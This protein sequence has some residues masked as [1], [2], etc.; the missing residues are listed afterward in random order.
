MSKI[1]WPELWEVIRAILKVILGIGIWLF[2]N[3][4]SKWHLDRD[5]AVDS[6]YGFIAGVLVA[7][8]HYAPKMKRLEL[9]EDNLGLLRHYE[10][11]IKEL[12]SSKKE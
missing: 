3:M 11:R 12:E 7:V 9:L 1:S 10:K 2:L 8:W 5:G 6:L 4:D